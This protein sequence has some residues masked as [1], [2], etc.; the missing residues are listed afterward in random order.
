MI[1]GCAINYVDSDGANH[2]LGF[3]HVVQHKVP[4]GSSEANIHQV[5]ALGFYFLEMGQQSSI[6]FGYTDTYEVSIEENRAIDLRIDKRKPAN[7]EFK[8][9]HSLLK[10]GGNNYE[11]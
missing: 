10:K 4:S 3:A 1:E 11:D 5:K 7:I 9:T 8:A 2:T 6:G